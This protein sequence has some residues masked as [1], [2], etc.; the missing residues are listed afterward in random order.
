MAKAAA[1]HAPIG[2]RICTVSAIRTTGRN[3]A[4]RR[5]ICEA[6][7]PILLIIFGGQRVEPDRALELGGRSK[8]AQLFWRRPEII[9]RFGGFYVMKNSRLRHS[10]RHRA[11]ACMQMQ[12][13]RAVSQS[14]RKLLEF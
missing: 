14:F 1:Q 6:T 2:A 7:R 11:G 12:I 13:K 3:F 5:R 9:C 8:T 10:S 4:K